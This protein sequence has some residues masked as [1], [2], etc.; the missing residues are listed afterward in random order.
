MTPRP[1]EAAPSTDLA[2]LRALRREADGHVSGAELAQQLGV[3][4]AAI[5]NRIRELRQ[6]G[7]DISASPQLGYRLESAPDLLLRDD[8]LARLGRT[9]VVGRDI[10]VFQET[11][12]TNDIVEKL[13]RD[14]VRE[15]VVVLA[16]SQ[17]RGRGRLGRKWV[18]PAGRGIWCS[19]LLRPKLAPL[20][21]TRLTIL[22]VVSLARAVHEVTGLDPEIKWP[23]DLLLSGRKVAGILTEMQ[24]ELEQV[25]HVILGIGVNANLDAGDFPPELRPVA[26]SLKLA[27]GAPMDRAALVVAFLRELDH[28]YARLCDGR[29]K[30]LAEEWAGRC[31]T[32]GREVCIRVGSREIRGRAESLDD[33]GALL[34]RSEHGHL[35][36]I[37][38]GEVTLAH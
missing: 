4:R 36:R 38:G 3:T 24:A 29:F 34:V 28:D 33:A 26:T 7:Y 22:A 21:A 5:W 23:N 1:V 6:H 9:Q 2:I 35:E 27:L 19:V 8:L 37:I 12:S 20:Q 31:S 32:L 14:G 11:A 15:G 16:E 18:S 17:T 30:E 13:A 10:H 25:R